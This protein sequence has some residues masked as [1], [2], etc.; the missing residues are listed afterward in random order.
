MQACMPK[1]L[2]AM[3]AIHACT[4]LAKWSNIAGCLCYVGIDV[5]TEQLC[6]LKLIAWIQVIDSGSCGSLRTL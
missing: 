4:T 6:N 2:M 3:H 5:M 1:Q